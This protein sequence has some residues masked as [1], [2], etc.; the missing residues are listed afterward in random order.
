MVCWWC[1]IFCETMQSDKR[2]VQTVFGKTQNFMVV[3][4]L[5]VIFGKYWPNQIVYELLMTC[6]YNVLKKISWWFF[7]S[8]CAFFKTCLFC[9]WNK[10]WWRSINFVW[11]V[12]RLTPVLI[13]TMLV[14]EV[15]YTY[16]ENYS[17]FW[18]DETHDLD[19]RE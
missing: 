12:C 19:C 14:S 6:T 1:T 18:V 16:L 3:T 8:L 9:V 15:M 17:P 2:S 11:F 4:L 5:I 7:F 10:K 13:A